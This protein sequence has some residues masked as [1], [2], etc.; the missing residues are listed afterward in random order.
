MKSSLR[1]VLVASVAGAAFMAASA[2]QAQEIN[3]GVILGFT[4]PIESLTPGMADSAELAFQEVN[5]SGL[6]LDGATI[7]PIRADST[8]I[9]SAAATAAAERLITAD[10]VAAIMGAFS[11]ATITSQPFMGFVQREPERALRLLTTK[12]SSFQA[13]MQ[14][15]IE[16]IL[17][18]ELEAGHLELPLPMH[19][20][21]YLAMR[22]TEAFVYADIITGQTPDPAKVQQAIGALLRD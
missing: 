8:C 6:L 20:L 9:D 21:S 14:G 1:K 15:L 17:R 5:D 12:A 22:I 13:K 2:A 19:D 7:N 18:E 16:E 3:I 10:E 11:R 4:G